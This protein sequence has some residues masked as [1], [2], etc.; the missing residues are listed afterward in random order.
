MPK[1]KDVLRTVAPSVA[2]ALGGPLAGTA[3]AAVSKVLL[4]NERGT[5]KEIEPLVLNASPET[6][7]KLKELELSF[8]T[9]MADAGIKLEEIEAGDRASARERQ[10]RMK[11]V[12]PNVIALAVFLSFV[13]LLT[14]MLYREVPSANRDAFNIMLGMLEGCLLTVMNYEFGSSRGSREKDAVLGKVV[15]DK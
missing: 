13:G 1:W 3:V 5:E 2:T 4:G 15:S 11:D 6:L 9:A 12:I 10:A 14:F 7:L 8:S